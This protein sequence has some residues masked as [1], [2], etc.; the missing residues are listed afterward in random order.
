[1]E[2]VIP[3]Q[4]YWQVHCPLIVDCFCVVDSISKKTQN[5]PKLNFGSAIQ[6]LRNNF[7]NILHLYRCRVIRRHYV[8]SRLAHNQKNVGSN[9]AIGIRIT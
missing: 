1:M 6:I 5:P 4:R 9:P 3:V 8:E 7:V 2:C